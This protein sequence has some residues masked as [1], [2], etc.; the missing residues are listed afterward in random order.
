MSIDGSVS[1][2]ESLV[3]EAL[4]EIVSSTDLHELNKNKARLL[5]RKGLLTEQLKRVGS[6]PAE[7]RSAFGQAVND[8]KQLLSTQTS[9]PTNASHSTLG[10][11]QQRMQCHRMGGT[12]GRRRVGCL[13][14]GLCVMHMH[15]YCVSV[16]HS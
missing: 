13:A 4:K 12:S 9:P 11:T 16:A 10:V 15:R 5:G 2:I 6:L 7:E 8:A 1:G 3:T 14:C